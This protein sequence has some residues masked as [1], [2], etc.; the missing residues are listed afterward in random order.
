MMFELSDE[1]IQLITKAL[2]ER[3]LIIEELG[4][5]TN[6]IQNLNNLAYKFQELGTD[7]SLRDKP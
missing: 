5:D 3:A 4:G 2:Q 6:T 7:K 1:E